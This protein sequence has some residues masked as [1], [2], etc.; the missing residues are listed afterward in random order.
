MAATPV[1][2]RVA[3]RHRTAMTGNPA[4]A[5][6]SVHSLGA[7]AQKTIDDAAMALVSALGHNDGHV[8]FTPGTSAALWL[9]VE[10]AIGRVVDRTARIAATEVEHPALLSALRRAEREG[11]A[12]LTMIAVDEHD[13]P[14][15]S[16]PAF[17]GLDR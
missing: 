2:P 1:D 3:E 8:T 17:G 9:A 4:N 16:V 14:R 12:T 13:T 11:R 6:S 7:D 10:D 5:H 15:C